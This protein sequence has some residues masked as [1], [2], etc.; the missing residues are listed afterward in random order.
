MLEVEIVSLETSLT[1]FARFT[2]TAVLSGTACVFCSGVIALL[3]C[4][5]LCSEVHFHKLLTGKAMRLG[6][7][8]LKSLK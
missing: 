8:L 3:S 7:D 5:R 1:T 6:C 4:D 2:D